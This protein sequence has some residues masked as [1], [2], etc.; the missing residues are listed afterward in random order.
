MMNANTGPTEP[1]YPP[2][3]QSLHWQKA[4]LWHGVGFL[5]LIVLT[6]C[7][8]LFDLMHYVLGHPAQTA[9]IEEVEIK[10]VLIVFLWMGSAY[11]LYQIVSRLSYLEKFLNVCSWCHRIQHHDAW[12][13]LEEHFQKDTGAEVSHG[14]CPEC[15]E[16]FQREVARSPIPAA[17]L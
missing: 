15:A 10:T 16:Q 6:W 14:I 2:P 1:G 3:K 11:K 4:L 17:S 5:T 9:N 13:S 7:D 12:L 8:G